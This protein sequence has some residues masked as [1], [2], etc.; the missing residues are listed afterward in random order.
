MKLFVFQPFAGQPLG[1]GNQRG[2]VLKMAQVPHA[3]FALIC[4][5]GARV[6]RE[7]HDGVEDVQRWGLRVMCVQQGKHL[8]LASALAGDLGQQRS[9]ER[10]CGR[11][12]LAQGAQQRKRAGGVAGL[13]RTDSAPGGY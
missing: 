10:Q 8:G 7:R 4:G 13:L 6:L 3:A 5:R 2:F 12:L 11:G 1:R 9:G